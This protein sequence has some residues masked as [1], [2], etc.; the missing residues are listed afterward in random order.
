MTHIQ[1]RRCGRR[2]SSASSRNSLAKLDSF[3]KAHSPE[4]AAKLTG[5]FDGI[6]PI[7]QSHQIGDRKVVLQLI[8]PAIWACRC[9]DNRMAHDC[10]FIPR[11]LP[12]L[13]VKLEGPCRLPLTFTSKKQ[14]WLPVRDLS[15]M[16]FVRGSRQR[17]PCGPKLRLRSRK[18][19]TT[20]KRQSRCASEPTH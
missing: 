1:P 14:R 17:R 9:K 20:E 16:I 5:R 18:P 13:S 19:I 7:Q 11:P 15:T 3:L 12:Q 10:Q 8:A 6:A 4:L 2:R